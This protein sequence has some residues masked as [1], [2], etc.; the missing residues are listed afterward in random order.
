MCFRG[1]QSID[2]TVK[3]GGPLPFAFDILTTVFEYGNRVFNKYPHDI[4]DYFKQSFPEG[5]S[6]E[7]ST[8]YEDCG[9]V[10]SSQ[11]T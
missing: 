8:T 4:A 6:W 11:A 5:H 9:I 7:R 10:A 1:K 2:L 3:D